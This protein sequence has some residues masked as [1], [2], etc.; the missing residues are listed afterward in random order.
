M[1]RV[2]DSDKVVLSLNYIAQPLMANPAKPRSQCEFLMDER[3]T[4]MRCAGIAKAFTTILAPASRAQPDIS[5]ENQILAKLGGPA[6]LTSRPAGE[7]VFQNPLP[8][9]PLGISESPPGKVKKFVQEN[10][11]QLRGPAGEGAIE[12]NCARTQISSSMDFC[13]CPSAG[14][15]L[16]TLHSEVLAELN[17]DHGIC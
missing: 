9:M 6:K 1:F 5:P 17:V 12:D 15:Q 13:S 16:S 11:P 10:A 4:Q 3:L 7:F 2:N 14:N 8:R